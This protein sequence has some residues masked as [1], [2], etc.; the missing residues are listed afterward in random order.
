M[1]W[2]EIAKR[3]LAAEADRGAGAWFPSTVHAIRNA[4]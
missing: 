4:T 1:D 3:V 2:Q